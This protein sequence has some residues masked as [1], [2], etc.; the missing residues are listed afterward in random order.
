MLGIM[1]IA[2]SAVSQ[3]QAAVIAVPN[4]LTSG[5]GNSNN[6]EPFSFPA[7][8]QQVF[9]ASQFSSLS[10]PALISTISFRPDA[11]FGQAFSITIPN[12]Q[13]SLSTTFA[14][15]DELNPIFSNNIG[16]DTKV[17]FGGPL[18]LSSAF[19]GPTV[20]PKTFDISIGL[21]NLFLYNFHEGNLL[22]DV[23]NFTTNLPMSAFDAQDV[24]GDSISRVFSSNVNSDTVFFGNGN[25]NDF[26]NSLGL[27]TQFTFAPVPEP[28][29]CVLL[30]LGVAGLAG[31][32]ALGTAPE[33]VGASRAGVNRCLLPSG[34]TKPG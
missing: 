17:V 21:Q 25:P 5:E 22:L 13:I 33:K 24:V 31:A 2:L 34:T 27:V 18:F 12:V 14:A 7:R 30:G 26:S 23:K 8:Y 20:G 16:A 6:S 15:P 11:V 29:T 10:A 3:T 1:L 4:V 9:A 32:S 19:T 28:G